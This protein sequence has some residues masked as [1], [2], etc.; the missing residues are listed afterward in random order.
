MIGSVILMEYRSGWKGLFIF[1]SLIFILSF[2]MPQLYPSYRDSLA[3]EL[4]GAHNVKLE[5]PEE[6]G[7]Q[8]TLSWNPTEGAQYIVLVDSRPS[9]VTAELLYAGNETTITFPKDFEEDRYYAVMAAVDDTR[10]LIGIASTGKGRDPL[11]DYMNSPMYAGFTGG[12]DISLLEAKGFI[13]LEFFSFWWILAGLFIAYVSVS[14]ITGD[15]EGKRMDLIFSTP[16]SRKHYILEKFITMSV[17]SLVIVLVAITGLTS[18]IANKG[19]SSEFESHTVVMALVGSL[20]FF[21]VIAAFGILTAVIFQ[22][23]RIGMG[24]TF[25]FVLVGFFLYTFGGYSEDLEWMKSLSIMN[26]WDYYSVIFDGVFKM[27]GFIG[28]FVAAFAVIGLA[29]LIFGKKDIPT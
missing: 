19:L 22:R 15:F 3:A 27:D 17:I 5:L 25:A 7:S 29:I 18:G 1:A 14:V 12:R 21:M 10:V 9:M 23:T 24:C 13:T 6:Q 20:P 8:I 2:G 26:Y 11:E 4:E 16:I 28:L